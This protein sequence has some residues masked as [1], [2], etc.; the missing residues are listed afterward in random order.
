MQELADASDVAG[1]P[2]ASHDQPGYPYTGAHV[3]V[4]AQGLSSFRKTFF[5][6]LALG[7]N[8]A[9]RSIGSDE[10]C[11]APFFLLT[12]DNFAAA[13]PASVYSRFSSTSIGAPLS[14]SISRARQQRRFRWQRLLNGRMSMFLPKG[15]TP[16]R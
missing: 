10:V 6:L 12:G 3:T 15:K 8:Q 14:P 16:V 13:Y 7:G 2:E 11:T 9:G 5:Q 4:E 1:S